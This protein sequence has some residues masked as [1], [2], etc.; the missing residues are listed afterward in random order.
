MARLLPLSKGCQYAVR[1]AALL[2]CKPVGT[3]FARQAVSNQ[4]KVPAGFLSK[5]LQTLTRAGILHSYRGRER[6][7]SLAR[8]ASRISLL[9][10]VT[11]YDGPLGHEGCLLDD[12]R[13]CPGERV[14][15]IH[16]QRMK[17]QKQL[18]QNLSSVNI[19]DVAKTLQKR[20]GRSSFNFM[21]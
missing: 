4:A 19:A 16:N 5:I 14:C 11:A 9:D 8:P 13:L 1:T 3:V 21:G 7:Y 12:Y 20:H 2:S 15:A 18:T 6:G 17:I 10:I